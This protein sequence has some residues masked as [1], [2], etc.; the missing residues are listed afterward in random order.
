MKGRKERYKRRRRNNPIYL[1][2]KKRGGGKR[3]WKGRG[4]KDTEEEEGIIQSGTILGKTGL[5]SESFGF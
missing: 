5:P 4:R 1:E 2:R 3:S